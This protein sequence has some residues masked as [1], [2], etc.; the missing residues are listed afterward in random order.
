MHRD[1]IK[2]VASMV[3]L[4]GT[5][6]WIRSDKP[7]ND[8]AIAQLTNPAGLAALF[9]NVMDQIEQGK[10]PA[11]AVHSIQYL[12]FIKDPVATVEDLYRQLGFSMTDRARRAMQTYIREHPRESRPAHKYDSGDAERLTQERSLFERYQSR[13]KVES[14]S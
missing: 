10:I 1:P 11:A 6:F 4:V 12:E 2:C 13:F 14:E 9:N 5:L 3:S 8:L 7:L